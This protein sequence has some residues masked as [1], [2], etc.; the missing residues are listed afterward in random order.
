MARQL[1]LVD[2]RPDARGVEGIH[3]KHQLLERGFQQFRDGGMRAAMMAFAPADNA[4]FRDDLH[5]H[6]IAL[7]RLANPKPRPGIGRQREGGWECLDV[8]DLH[9]AILMLAGNE[10]CHH[11]RAFA[12]TSHPSQ[13]E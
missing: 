5:H 11:G 1:I 9:A 6:R 3:A 7:H 12:K 4:I 13:H 2:A 8:H 10:A